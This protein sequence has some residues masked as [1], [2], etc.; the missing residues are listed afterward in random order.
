[1]N[2]DMPAYV[3]DTHTLIW[4]LSDFRKL[5]KQAQAVFGEIERGNA[6]ALIPA[7]VLAEVIFLAE[8]KGVGVTLAETMA[9]IELA[10]N[11]EIALMDLDILKRLVVL[12]EIPELHDR[13]IAATALENNSILITKDKEI[14]KSGAVQTI[15]Q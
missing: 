9:R 2:Y 11:F 8:K 15:W 7:I 1:M 14:I 4:Y 5:G 6:I 13:I 3:L 10:D 12:R